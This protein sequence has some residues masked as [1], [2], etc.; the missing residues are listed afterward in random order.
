MDDFSPHGSNINHSDAG[1]L[2]SFEK[3]CFGRS[4]PV[5]S[6]RKRPSADDG[7]GQK[8][9]NRYLAEGGDRPRVASLRRTN[10]AIIW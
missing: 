9:A 4:L 10:I 7:D 3:G 2:A 8:S 5:A 1:G 6:G